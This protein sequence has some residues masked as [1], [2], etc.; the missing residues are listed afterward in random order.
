MSYTMHC[1]EFFSSAH[2]LLL[3]AAS[4]G[5]GVTVDFDRSAILSFVIFLLLFFALKPVLLD[6]FLKVVEAREKRTTG[7]KAEARAM[8]ER[9]AEII[10]RYEGELE[11]VRKVANEERERFRS[12]AQSLEAKILGEARAEA[13]RVTAEGKERIRLEAETV[14]LE[15]ERMSSEL[16]KE[17]ASKVLGREI[18]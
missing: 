17:A 6:P 8:D 10:K 12:E 18:S 1:S 7:A 14:R 9:A 2:V 3:S 5:P 16:A 4:E 15:L 13:M 11:K